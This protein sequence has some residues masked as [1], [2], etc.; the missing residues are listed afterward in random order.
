MEVLQKKVQNFGH[1]PNRQGGVSNPGLPM[2][3]AYK[4]VFR[5]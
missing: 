1:C 2:S 5:G 3:E 4:F